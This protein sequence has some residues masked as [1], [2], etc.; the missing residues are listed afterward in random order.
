MPH[1]TLQAGHQG[2][3]L[4]FLIGIS[5]PRADVLKAAGQLVPQPVP[6]RGLID[7]GA[8]CTCVDPALILPLGLTATG[9]VQVHTPSTQ[10]SAHSCSQYDVSFLIH[11]PRNSP[12][13]PAIPVLATL[14]ASQGIQALIGRD[15]LSMCLL[16]YD[17]TAG[18]FSLSF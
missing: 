14:L 17:G 3:L 4:D 5:A 1:L 13:V 9:N 12:V 11:H 18:T 16:V 6:L 10:G 8:S 2:P 7:T 15:V